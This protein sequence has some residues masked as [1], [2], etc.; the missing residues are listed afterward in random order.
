MSEDIKKTVTALISTSF[1]AHCGKRA[2]VRGCLSVCVLGPEPE[3]LYSIIRY[4][5]VPSLRSQW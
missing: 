1:P 3:P 5:T 2:C 4:P